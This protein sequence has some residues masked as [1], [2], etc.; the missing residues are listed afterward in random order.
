MAVGFYGKLPS[1]GDFIQRGITDGFVNRWDAWLQEGLARSR[2][3]LGDPW[4]SLF[5]TSPVWRFVLSRG[6]VDGSNWAGI[7]LPSID[8]ANRCFPLTIVAEL[9]PQA[10]PFEVSALAEGWFDWVEAVARRVLDEEVLDLAELQAQLAS[11]DALLDPTRMTSGEDDPQSGSVDSRGI[12]R[13]ALEPDLNMARFWARRSARLMLQQDAPAGLWWTAGSEWVRPSVLLT[14]GLPPPESFRELLV[15]PADGRSD[16]FTDT[17]AGPG[18]LFHANAVPGSLEPHVATPSRVNSAGLTDVG[19][20]REENQDAFLERPDSGVWLVADGMGGHQAGSLASRLIVERVQAADLT[21]GLTEAVATLK[22]SLLA[23]NAD[24]RRRAQEQPGFDA[25]STVVA[26]CVRGEV[27][28]ALWAGD[29]R[30]Y[31]LRAGTFAQLTQDHSLLAEAGAQI[32]PADSHIITRAVG[33]G[34]QLDVEERRFEVLAG[35]RFLLCTDGLYEG[36][37]PSELASGLGRGNCSEAAH[38]LL[39]S[40]LRH[41]G[42][43]NLTAV[44]VGVAQAGI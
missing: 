26:L 20:T 9:G 6:M 18:E 43:D 3:A 27:G 32:D 11:S 17:M 31:R 40:A 42:Q 24:L 23:V 35:D 21:G 28:A 5:L 33:G 7:L 15:G 2:E 29:S 14:R 12:Q 8:R 13:F 44:C 39:A 19:R 34:D 16:P 41:G 22:A 37:T 25:G 4:V 1:H 38:E 30:L 10:Q 36:L